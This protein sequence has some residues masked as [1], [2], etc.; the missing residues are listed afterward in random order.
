MTKEEVKNLILSK[1]SDI[2]ELTLYYYVNYF[3]ALINSEV[4]INDVSINEL[5]ENALYYAKRIVFYD[6]NSEIYKRLGPDCKGLREPADHTIYIRDNLPDPLRE[7][8][9]YHELHHAVQT[10]RENDM[11]GINYVSNYC[12]MIMEAQTQYF[13]EKVYEI[14]HNVIFEER[15]IPSENLRMKKGGT[16]VST[17]H[18][19]EMYDSLL[20]KLSIVLDVP[21][22]YFVSINYMYENN[23]GLEDFKKLYNKKKEEL[24]LPYEFDTLMYAFDY[25]YVT[26]LMAYVENEDKQVILSGNETKDPYKIYDNRVE[27]LSLEAEYNKIYYIDRSFLLCLLNGNHDYNTYIKYILSD[28]TRSMAYEILGMVPKNE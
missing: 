8:T 18:N 26:D 11:A 7:I 10:N 4:L 22:D 25:I 28:E 19:Y 15:F 27:K 14:N 6:E 12:R 16:I 1:K 23:K 3:Y 2:D 9:V 17:L 20:T 21:K 13:A 5:I 24:K